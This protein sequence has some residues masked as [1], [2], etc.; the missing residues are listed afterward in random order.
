MYHAVRSTLVL[1]FLFVAT[2]AS[3]G[4]FIDDDFESS[5]L[6]AFPAGWSD[7]GQVPGATGNA[8]NPSMVVV[9]TTGPFGGATRAASLVDDFADSQGIYQTIPNHPIVGISFDVRVDRY[10]STSGATFNDWA[11]D[12]TLSVVGSQDLSVA[13]A[14]GTF[15]TAFDTSVGTFV[16]GYTGGTDE[17]DT[18]A[19]M[20]TGVWYNVNLV[21]NR[22]AGT[23]KIVVTDIVATSTL[24]STTRTVPGWSGFAS[25]P[26]YNAVAILDG[27]LS[28]TTL[29]NLA[30]YDNVMVADM[31]IPITLP[32]AAVCG[33]GVLETG[34]SCD[35]GASNGTFGSCCS[36][37]CQI[38][39]AATACR[40]SAGDC[41]VAEACNGVSPTCPANGFVAAGNP[42]RPSA[43][44]CDVAEACTGSS[45]TCP[46]DGFAAAGNEC[47]A[48]AGDCDVAEACSGS[49]ASCPPDGFVATGNECRAAG[50]DCD[51]A[52]EC[53][54]A[55]AACPP[56]VLTPAGTECRSSAGP[57][58]Q[59]E[60]CD[61]VDPNC[62]S[63]ATVAATTGCTV[64][65]VPGQPCQADDS[66]QT[67]VGTSGDDVIVGGAGDDTLKGRQGNDLLC[68]LDG[69]DTITGAGGS[70]ELDGGPGDD[71]LR[72]EEGDDTLSGGP[73]DDMLIGGGANDMLDGGDGM[74]VLR[75]DAGNDD[76]LGGPGNDLARGGAGMDMILGEGGDDEIFGDGADDILDGGTETDTINGGAGTDTCDGETETKC[77]L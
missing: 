31:E 19:D 12:A 41:D 14:F 27:E 8:T 72:G 60:Q 11:W 25:E 9:S 4:V 47:R 17:F 66:G 67:V 45:A 69:N 77:E 36:S 20:P 58:D 39:P 6:G 3:A 64:D 56:D 49:S 21:L 43:G 70:D 42:C 68:G 65:G 61:G 26:T 22:T 16:Q 38:E 62:P 46:P 18:G 13:P 73:D 35:Q 52:E 1:A 50:G 5:P 59:A 28:A 32:S 29:T 44:I 76:L 55:S 30:V 7:V 53:D 74:D 24:V 37:S 63:D 2:P 48:S 71:T 34:E 54:G 51:A 75:G 40:A 57:C 15:A 23:I 10:A 33:N